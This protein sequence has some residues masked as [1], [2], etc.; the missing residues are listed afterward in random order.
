MIQVSPYVAFLSLLLSSALACCGWQWTAGGQ[1]IPEAILGGPGFNAEN[2]RGPYHEREK[3]VLPSTPFTAGL[4]HQD[5]LIRLQTWNRR[6]GWDH[7]TVLPIQPQQLGTS[8]GRAALWCALYA[9]A[10]VQVL[11]PPPA[12]E[13]LR[14]WL[15]PA[16]VGARDLREFQGFFLK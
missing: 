8:E 9:G 4:T 15:A 13:G 2:G 10:H 16:P 5:L 11:H 12:A 3:E 1:P 6:L 14:R 7:T